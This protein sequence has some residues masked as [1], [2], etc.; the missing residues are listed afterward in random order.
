MNTGHRLHV[1]SGEDSRTGGHQS[2]GHTST[3]E[4]V[5]FS[6]GR[7]AL[8]VFPIDASSGVYGQDGGGHQRLSGA[9]FRPVAIS[10]DDK[11]II[12]HSR[13]M[14][15][16]GRYGLYHHQQRGGQDGH[17]LFGQDRTSR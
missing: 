1:L 6:G 8:V 5:D 16:E 10:R 12:P 4:Y 9:S 13:D 15:Y 2:A 11:T 17:E 7:L 14:F 3:T